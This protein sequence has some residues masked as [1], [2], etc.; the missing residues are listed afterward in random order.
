MHE[1]HRPNRLAAAGRAA[2]VVL[3][4]LTAASC[5]YEQPVP[6][7]QPGPSKF[8]RAWEAARAAAED[9]GVTVTDVD[10]SSGTIRG[11]RDATNVTI[12]VWQQADGSVR[13]AF[14]VRAP[15]GPDAA[16]ADRLSHAYDRRM[17]R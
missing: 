9:V 13:V 11:Y 17:G 16:L 14:N 6:V 12:T 8:D 3:A 1:N 4:M 2:L 7:Y 10:R 15:S 5:V